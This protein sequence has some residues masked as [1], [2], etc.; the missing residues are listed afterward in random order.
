MGPRPTVAQLVQLPV[1]AGSTCQQLTPQLEEF[2]LEV[3][4][5]FRDWVWST[6]VTNRSEKLR[7]SVID[8]KS[9]V[10]TVG[11][12]QGSNEGVILQDRDSELVDEGS[13]SSWVSTPPSREVV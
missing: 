1:K 11:G 5:S 13:E 4:D 2:A 6:K 3:P 9:R 7:L 12:L 10:V 8:F